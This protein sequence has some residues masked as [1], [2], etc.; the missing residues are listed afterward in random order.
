MMKKC[1]SVFCALFLVIAVSSCKEKTPV[2][3]AVE[4]TQ[5]STNPAFEPITSP[6]AEKG[7][8][9][10]KSTQI[11]GI[12]ITEPLEIKPV[13]KAK[14]SA[15]WMDDLEAAKK[16]AARENKD[17]LV[18]FSGSEWCAVCV[19][20]D[21]EVFSK[22]DF[23][24]GASKRFVPVVLD[25]PREIELASEKLKK[26]YVE[27]DH[28][29]KFPTVYLA[30]SDGRPYAKTSYIPGGPRRYLEHLEEFRTAKT[31]YDRLMKQARNDELA[32]VEKAKLIEKAVLTVNPALLKLFY[33]DLLKRIVALDKN[34]EAQLKQKYELQ[35]RMWDAIDLFEAGK[36]ADALKAVDAMIEDM[37]LTDQVLQETLFF[38]SRLQFVMQDRNGAL[39]SLNTAVEAGPET[40][41]AEQIKEIISKYFSDLTPK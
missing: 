38:K 16:T 28:D 11:P 37:K 27:F 41:M 13:E 32:D 29:G 15:F 7:I 23:Q 12:E 39:K 30:D 25:F 35:V 21:R 1:I 6:D 2:T 22:E 8:V 17:L 14:A 4:N 20:L 9:E 31:E 18:N 36:R 5:E 10:L 24:L 26:A 19:R 40:R 34:N 3:V 33:R